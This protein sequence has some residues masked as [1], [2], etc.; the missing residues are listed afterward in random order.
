MNVFVCVVCKFLI[1]RPVRDT[2]IS[3]DHHDMVSKKRSISDIKRQA[4]NSL[5]TAVRINSTT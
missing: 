1:A 3:R 2:A 5:I 4:S